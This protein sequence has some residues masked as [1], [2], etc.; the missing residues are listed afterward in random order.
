MVERS[1][2]VADIPIEMACTGPQHSDCDSRAVRALVLVENDGEQAGGRVTVRFFCDRHADEIH[3][4][5]NAEHQ[6][7]IRGQSH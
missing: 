3:A 5:F 2:F 4:M 1:P 7:V 6:G